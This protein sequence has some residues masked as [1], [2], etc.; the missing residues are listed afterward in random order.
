[1]SVVQ[2]GE[3]ELDATREMN[4]PIFVSDRQRRNT[5]ISKDRLIQES[6]EL[7]K[8][9]AP[10]S[11]VPDFSLPITKRSLVFAPFTR[12]VHNGIQDVPPKRR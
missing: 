1:L 8:F 11:R 10:Y 4:E 12:A 6:T 2:D 3:V 5:I 7:V 9:G